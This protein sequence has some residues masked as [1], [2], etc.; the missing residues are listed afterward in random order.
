MTLN[1]Q[2]EMGMYA[3]FFFEFESPLSAGKKVAVG[4]AEWIEDFLP[5]DNGDV[6]LIKVSCMWPK[7]QFLL[8]KKL[9]NLKE[10]D[11]LDNYFQAIVLFH[12][13]GKI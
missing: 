10:S 4:L 2:A 8:S 13:D 7:D 12:S 1:F 9:S 5:G 6:T 3:L 11:F